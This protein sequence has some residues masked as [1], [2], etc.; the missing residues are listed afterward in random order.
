VPF[1]TDR[2]DT[3][4]EQSLISDHRILL[5]CSPPY[6]KKNRQ[7][8]TEQQNLINVSE[9]WID[10]ANSKENRMLSYHPPRKENIR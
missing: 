3:K 6:V 8:K 5:I 7:N 10:T 1:K 9:L 4:N 2:L